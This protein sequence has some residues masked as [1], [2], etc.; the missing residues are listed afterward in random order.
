MEAFKR[1]N[2]VLWVAL[3]CTGGSPWQ[4][5]NKMKPGGEENL[6]EHHK[7]FQDIWAKF[8]KVAKVCRAHGGKIAFEWPTGCEYWRWQVIK[9]FVNKYQLNK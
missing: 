9:D 4:H 5:I 3:P 1:P 7:L 6:R 2:C 8:L